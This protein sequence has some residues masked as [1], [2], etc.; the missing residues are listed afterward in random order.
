VF[1]NREGRR[2]FGG[3]RDEVI[4][5]WRKVHTEELHSMEHSFIHKQSY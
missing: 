5:M 2:I 3:K 4:G 1:E